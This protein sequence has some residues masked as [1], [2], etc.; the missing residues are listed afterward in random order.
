MAEELS[1]HFETLQLH[2]GYGYYL[3]HVVTISSMLIANYVTANSQTRQ[4][5]LVQFQFTP[6]LCVHLRE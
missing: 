3:L 4:Q 1:K 2:A 6:Q 5:M